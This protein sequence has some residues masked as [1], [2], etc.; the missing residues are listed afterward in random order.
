MHQ[1]INCVIVKLTCSYIFIHPRHHSFL[2]K[3]FT[4]FFYCFNFCFALCLNIASIVSQNFLWLLS[5]LFH[6][7]TK[8]GNKWK[9]N[10]FDLGL[11]KSIYLYD[12]MSTNCKKGYRFSCPKPDYSRPGRVWTGISLTFFYS[13]VHSILLYYFNWPL[14]GD[15]C[16][17]RFQNNFKDWVLRLS[18]SAVS[19]PL[20]LNAAYA[21]GDDF[22]DFTE[23]FLSSHYI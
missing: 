20:S 2:C 8:S 3:C 21:A 5:L 6:S 4:G 9:P 18:F 16:E 14:K 22:T 13:A 12:N 11:I 1:S 23:S 10:C 17:I 19:A 15:P 7:F